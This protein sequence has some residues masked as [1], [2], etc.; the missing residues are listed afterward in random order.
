[1]SAVYI[2]EEV[3]SVID[4][5][6]EINS[7]LN[8]LHFLTD[9]A[10]VLHHGHQS[11]HPGAAIGVTCWHPDLIG[12]EAGQIF[13]TP[14]SEDDAKLTISRIHG[15]LNWEEVIYSNIY[16]NNRFELAID[17]LLCGDIDTLEHVITES[18]ELVNL[19]SNYPH[20]ATL[21]HYCA[22][23]GLET[24]R[25]VVPDNLL[26]IVELLIAKGA[27]K[28]AKMKVYNGEHTASELAATSVHPLKAGIAAQLIDKLN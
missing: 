20:H 22:S 16:L 6:Q 28:K 10:E 15:F 17:N 1:M 24:E 8:V 13:D 18:P 2:S 25:Q 27:D 11:K 4:L 5:Y 14:F 21:L 9:K 3:A 19:N 23:N 12:K 7:S 26:E